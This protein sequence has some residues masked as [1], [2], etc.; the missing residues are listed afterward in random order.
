MSYNFIFNGFKSISLS[1]FGGQYIYQD[2]D[3]PDQEYNRI[4]S[5]QMDVTMKSFLIKMSVMGLSLAASQVGPVYVFISNRIKTTTTEVRI[6]FTEPES[7]AE[8]I[9][10]LIIQ[11]NISIHGMFGYIGM[12]V[13][14]SL[15][16]NI[17]NISPAL[18]KLEM[19]QISQQYKSK[20][21]SKSH[22]R[23]I[24][25]NLIQQ[26]TDIDE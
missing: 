7:N 19:K 13:W 17:V 3:Y 4:C 20:S 22:M 21:I 8:F 24:F 23:S 9:V 26:S 18:F 25:R 6:P 2:S 16:E 12:E 15:V 1:S 5:N 14:M 11:F 10:N